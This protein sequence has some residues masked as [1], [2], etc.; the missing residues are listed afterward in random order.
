MRAPR[1][2]PRRSRGPGRGFHRRREGE[3]A[4]KDAAA[5]GGRRA[6]EVDGVAGALADLGA[7]FETKAAELATR[8]LNLCGSERDLADRNDALVQRECA[9]LERESAA[10]HREKILGELHDAVELRKEAVES[11]GRERAEALEAMQAALTARDRALAAREAGAQGE[12]DAATRAAQ[13]EALTA[14]AQVAE[15]ETLAATAASTAAEAKFEKMREVAGTATELAQRLEEA[16]GKQQELLENLAGDRER[17][18][19]EPAPR[20]SDSRE[21]PARRSARGRIG[22][23]VEPAAA[24]GSRD[25]ANRERLRDAL[26]RASRAPGRARR[27]AS[28]RSVSWPWRNTPRKASARRC[29]L[30]TAVEKIAAWRR[31][32][33]QTPRRSPRHEPRRRQRRR[34]LQPPFPSVSSRDADA[35]DAAKERAVALAEIATASA[36]RSSRKRAHIV[37]LQAAAEA[38]SSENRTPDATGP[39]GSPARIPNHADATTVD[40]ATPTTATPSATPTTTTPP[41]LKAAREEL[42]RAR[43]QLHDALGESRAA[44]EALAASERRAKVA[45]GA[46]KSAAERAPRRSL[47]RGGALRRRCAS[48]RRARSGGGGDGAPR[49]RNRRARTRPRRR[50]RTVRPRRDGDV[51]IWAERADEAERRT[52]AASRRRREGDGNRRVRRRVR[53]DS[54]GDRHRTGDLLAATCAPRRPS[55][56]RASSATGIEPEA[57]W[58]LRKRRAPPEPLVVL[59]HHA[60]T[61]AATRWTEG[62]SGEGVD[63]FE[64]GRLEG[65]VCAAT[66][67]IVGCLREAAE[68]AAGVYARVHEAMGANAKQSSGANAKR[69]S[70]ANAKQ[71]SWTSPGSAGG[72]SV[73]VSVAADGNDGRIGGVSARRR[74]RG[75]ISPTAR[76]RR[77]ARRRR[78]RTPRRGARGAEEGS[79]TGRRW[80]ARRV[81]RCRDSTP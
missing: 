53:G 11:A 17:I 46:A 12:G 70:G 4:A 10:A 33:R 27:R 58:R 80:S 64:G 6:A 34:L 62:V 30:G 72:V 61:A 14:R 26:A 40:G 57:G 20:T 43:A 31:Q 47:L 18:A 79:W 76:I 16:L 7:G 55:S 23:G 35:D 63:E 66:R 48:R 15:A 13:I 51:G 74:R 54:V 69:V 71:V 44:R 39:D 3:A 45:E 24:R 52:N 1:G 29:A 36:G 28:P 22:A 5:T 38:R 32:R 68:A 2:C 77:R 78:G 67:D 49:P 25:E 9:L 65:R 37:A 60:A 21:R 81:R 73:G 42:D 56:R 41:E 75:R 19:E 8:E 59:A 50:T